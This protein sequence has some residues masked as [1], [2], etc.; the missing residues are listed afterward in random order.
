MVRAP[1]PRLKVRRAARP[2]HPA[3]G[4]GWALAVLVPW[5]SGTGPR[6]GQIA[7][8]IV[9]THKLCDNAGQRQ[10][11]SPF[12]S[13]LLQKFLKVFPVTNPLD[14]SRSA[15]C[16]RGSAGSGL[17]YAPSPHPPLCPNGGV[18]KRHR[19]LV[20]QNFKSMKWAFSPL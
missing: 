12:N 13:R 19:V 17:H 8:G 16:R 7:L 18:S 6:K 14:A 5:S 11:A 3:G 1:Y 15:P 20:P 2:G 4:A 10:A 9:Y